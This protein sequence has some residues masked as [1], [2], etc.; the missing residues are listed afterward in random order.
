MADRPFTSRR[1][2]L[3]GALLGFALML[4]WSG[5]LLAASAREE[6]FGD[7]SV[8]CEKRS[9][10]QAERCYMFQFVFVGKR[11]GEQR[12]QRV[13]DAKIAYTDKD[14]PPVLA[15]K[16]PLGVY[17]PSGILFRIDDGET[18]RLQLEW[19]VRDGCLTIAELA[20]MTRERLDLMKR[21]AEPGPADD[22]RKESA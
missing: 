6:T 11:D 5:P 8:R 18:L 3:P 21:V 10:E 7:W 2:R 16:V 20:R 9:E 14:Q 19:C 4:V 15:L 22:R 12:K 17:L 13:L 1:G